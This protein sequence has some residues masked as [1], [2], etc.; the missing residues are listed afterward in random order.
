MALVIKLSFD[1]V[2]TLRISSICRE[3][4]KCRLCPLVKNSGQGRFK[5]I[6][7]LLKYLLGNWR[8]YSQ[9]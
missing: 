9:P 2:K 1:F 3:G 8:N 4:T 5:Y 6:K 7:Y